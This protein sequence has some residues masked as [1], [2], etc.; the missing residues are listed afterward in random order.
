MAERKRALATSERR[1]YRLIDSNVI[2]IAFATGE[3]VTEANDEFLR[4][5]RYS[6]ADL[7]AGLSWRDMTPPEY[8]DLDDRCLAELERRGECTPLAV[9]SCPARRTGFVT[10]TTAPLRR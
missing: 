7:D 1:A 5:I 2:G 8:R 9:R 4:T 10:A 6:G 3:R